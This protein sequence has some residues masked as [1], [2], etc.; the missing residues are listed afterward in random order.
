MASADAYA[1]CHS[2]RALSGAW[3]ANDRYS[4]R[5][6]LTRY[7][8][9]PDVP[10]SIGGITNRWSTWPAMSNSCSQRP[11][12]RPSRRRYAGPSRL[13]V[14]SGG[15]A[16]GRQRPRR[17]GRDDRSAR[18][19]ECD[20]GPTA[21]TGARTRLGADRCRPMGTDATTRA[22][23]PMSWSPP[24]HRRMIEHVPARMSV[25]SRQRGI[26][27]G[28]QRGRRISQRGRRTSRTRS[29]ITSAGSG[30]SG[31]GVPVTDGVAT[32]ARR[33]NRTCSRRM[34]IGTAERSGP[35]SSAFLGRVVHKH[36][37][38]D[39]GQSSAERRVVGTKRVELAQC[40]LDARPPQRVARR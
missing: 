15:S 21:A 10:A 8:P 32:S 25:Q 22:T 1:S 34:S 6:A 17:H 30:V 29:K 9:A 11:A 18:T 37:T 19:H 27:G 20:W 40:H 33:M 24:G 5:Y 28:S 23:P 35:N 7:G 4:G 3:P 14:R 16:H 31:F 39:A 26:E 38:A 12:G 13:P 36:D 2:R